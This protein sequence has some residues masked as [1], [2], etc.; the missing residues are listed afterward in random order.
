MRNVSRSVAARR[1]RPPSSMPLPGIAALRRGV[2]FLLRRAFTLD[3]RALAVFRV[4]LGLAMIVDSLQIL[5]WLYKLIGDDS[6]S[7]RWLSVFSHSYF[8]L[9]NSSGDAWF[10]TLIF[11]LYYLTALAIIV[12]FH[13][14]TALLAAFVLYSSVQHANYYI[15]SGATVLLKMYLLWA[16]F[17]P[18]SARWSLDAALRPR[19]P[20]AQAEVFS[21]SSAVLVAQIAMLYLMSFALKTGADWHE[22]SALEKVIRYQMAMI[23]PWVTGLLAYPALL[24]FLTYFALGLELVAPLLILLGGWPR[25]LGML[26]LIGMHVGFDL[27]LALGAFPT[28]AIAGLLV[29]IPTQVWNLRKRR[30]AEGLV[31]FCDSSPRS[32]RSVRLVRSWLCLDG[33]EL[34][35]FSRD[36]RAAAL[37]AASG[38]WVLRSAQDQ[39][40]TGG[41]VLIE[42]VRHSPFKP[43]GYVLGLR[44]LRSLLKWTFAR[45]A[46]HRAGVDAALPAY[47]P[48]FW[49][50]PYLSEITVL[51]LAIGALGSNLLTARND[52]SRVPGYVSALGLMQDWRMFAPLVGKQSGWL[53][54]EGH[55]YSGRAVEPYQYLVHGR[56]EISYERPRKPNAFLGGERWRKYVEAAAYDSNLS[57]FFAGYL[58][59]YWA[60]RQSDAFQSIK[61]FYFEEFEGSPAQ[62][63][64]L[65]EGTCP[66]YN[67]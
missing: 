61:L 9:L 56:T 24:K 66:S 29:L 54:A 12:G 64:V 31:L 20:Q 52:F 49:R 32:E 53:V 34:Q 44:P 36:P 23:E 59:H 19:P 46:R 42:L 47:H 63:R 45:A 39:R 14:N 58:C 60:R 22:G 27:F 17:L 21:I 35:P 13:A 50:L 4:A 25:L 26:L 55:T 3:V 2:T 16:A 18:V 62:M 15:D 43:L 7:P 40:L 11:A 48:P 1:G 6:V 65:Y 41:D 67:F 30:F 33:L 28:V 37:H 10:V 51:V 8:S 57:R 38:S 5:P